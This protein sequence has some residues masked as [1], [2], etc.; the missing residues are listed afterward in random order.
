MILT[1]P[2]VPTKSAPPK[3]EGHVSYYLGAACMALAFGCM[4][5]GNMSKEIVKQAGYD[6][7]ALA[8]ACT[9][10]YLLSKEDYTSNKSTNH[11]SYKE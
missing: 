2:Q 9:S 7:V 11:N 8:L 3:K 6:V 5:K 4:I 10:G 1:A